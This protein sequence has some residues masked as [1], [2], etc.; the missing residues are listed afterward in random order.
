MRSKLSD[1]PKERRKRDAEEDD[2]ETDK[3][4]RLAPSKADRTPWYTKAKEESI[5]QLD[6]PKRYVF[7]SKIY[8]FTKRLLNL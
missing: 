8:C 2:A 6:A 3:G 4:Y 7:M 5:P 1:R